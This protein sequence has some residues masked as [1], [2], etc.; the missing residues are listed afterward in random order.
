MPNSDLL[1]QTTC[2]NDGSPVLT[3]TRAWDYGMRLRSIAN[4][5]TNGTAVSSHQYRYDSLNRRIQAALEDGSV[6]NYDYNDRNELIGARR[7]WPD[8][9]PVAGQQ[10]AY[11]YDNIGNRKSAAS[12]GDVNGCNVRW[13]YYS[14]NA[15]NQY[16][17]VLTP[18]FKDIMGAALAHNSVGVTNT[19]TSAEGVAD[20]KGE[21]FHRELSVHNT[22]GP[23][24]QTVS[25]TSGGSVSNGGFAF[26]KYNQNLT[27]DADGN[28][29]FDGIW[30]YEWD[31]E[32]RLKGTSMTNTLAN[33]ASSNCLRLDFTY[34]FQGRR[35]KK[36][37]RHED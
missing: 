6:W 2:K 8:W 18:G 13:S 31:G 16:T 22:N 37:L 10:S 12:G 25:V 17:N 7:Y 9:S 28:L 24:W 1:Q 5:T 33:L 4:V 20:R 11:D 29:T 14:A 26:P 23:L 34:D 36:M 21:Y 3:T 19:L 27:Y 35:I 15:V 30:T 32:N